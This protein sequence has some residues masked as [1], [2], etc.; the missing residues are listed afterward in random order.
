LIN[1]ATGF[2]PA[3]VLAAAG[4]P[5]NTATTTT[6]DSKG[7]VTSTTT[8][9]ST[10]GAVSNGFGTNSN[11][12]KFGWVGGSTTGFI[13]ALETLGETKVLAAPRL[14]VLNKQR[15]EVH[16]GDQL[17]YITSTQTQTSTTETVNFMPTGTQLRLRPFVSSDGMI[18][19]E[20]H[21]ERSSGALDGKGIP[22]TNAQQ[23]TTNVMIPD[24]ATIVIGGLIDTEVTH[25]WAGVPLL[26]R[27]PW[28][29]YLFRDTT[30]ET[31]KRELI[32]IITPHIWRP[33][34]PEATNY[35]GRPRTQGLDTRAAQKP[36]ED[37]RDGANLYEL[38]RPEGACPAPFNHPLPDRIPIEARREAPANGKQPAGPSRL[39]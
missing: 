21:P 25:G 31:K 32:V 11:G 8:K 1:A 36:C 9:T 17:G 19:M 5:N 22:Q 28:I 34:C 20:V 3:A 23:V 4:T 38:T 12:V 39:N 7:T 29:G 14:L 16:L 24:G 26:S 27:L 18:R 6:T 33:E 15:A 30:D 37:R 2:A 10:T 13:K 35:L